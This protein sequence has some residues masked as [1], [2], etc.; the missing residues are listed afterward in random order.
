MQ[1]TEIIKNPPGVYKRYPYSISF[2]C[3]TCG[4]IV[5]SFYRIR[6]HI[7]GHHLGLYKCPICNKQVT[8]RGLISKHI[9]LAHSKVDPNPCHVCGR[10]LKGDRSGYN[11]H[12]WTHLSEDEKKD[13][14][15]KS[16][17]PAETD[18]SKPKS[19]RQ[20]FMCSYCSKTFS[21]PSALK[22]HELEHTGEITYQCQM[23]GNLYKNG[24][25]LYQHVSRCEQKQKG[26]SLPKGR[27]SC[28]KCPARFTYRSTKSKHMRK[29]HPKD[30]L[31]YPFSCQKCHR[32]FSN[33]TALGNHK[34]HC[35][36]GQTKRMKFEQ[37]PAAHSSTTLMTMTA[38]ENASKYNPGNASE[39][40]SASS[41]HETPGLSHFMNRNDNDLI[42]SSSHATSA[43]MFNYMFEHASH[44]E[45]P[46]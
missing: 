39:S 44:Q 28:P 2:T 43:P 20:T 7:C 24:K 15:Y 12:I 22:R 33:K 37:E 21:V 27:L 9:K 42:Q 10:P 41:S 16:Y 18:G 11:R 29:F 35:G 1:G 19:T 30:T 14:Q 4:K 38:D 40:P 13:S 36:G 5:P 46:R 6:L 8:E 34:R 31:H 25:S 23:C 32:G 3:G 17:G 26:I 45:P